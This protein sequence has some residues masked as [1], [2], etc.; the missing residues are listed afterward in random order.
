MFTGQLP[1]KTGGRRWRIRQACCPTHALGPGGLEHH[2]RGIERL[3]AD[4]RK[5]N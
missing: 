1:Y 2:I 5:R 4:G 3:I